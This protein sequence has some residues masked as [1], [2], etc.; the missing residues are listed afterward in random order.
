MRERIK[1]DMDVSIVIAT[2]VFVWTC[3]CVY[4]QDAGMKTMGLLAFYLS[5]AGKAFTESISGGSISR[6]INILSIAKY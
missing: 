3:W 4:G 2:W 5:S 1:K 6:R